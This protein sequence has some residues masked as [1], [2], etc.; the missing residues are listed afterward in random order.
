ME[1]E[2]EIGEV[3]E[4]G[5]GIFTM[6]DIQRLEKTIGDMGQ[7]LS[8]QIEAA[9]TRV[10]RRIDVVDKNVDDLGE[11]VRDL[12]TFKAVTESR[13]AS[14]QKEIEGNRADLGRLQSEI[15][16]SEGSCRERFIGVDLA[17]TKKADE[18]KVEEKLSA[19]EE[20]VVTKESVR[21][22]MLGAT[23]VG[24]IVGGGGVI[25]ALKLLGGL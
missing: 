22:A 18:S 17:L 11:D 7:A 14:G 12:L 23:I 4:F 25:G 1:V 2:L 6:S 20:K 8:K 21:M 15:A 24:A 13:L 5:E 3:G 10:I 9:E 16:R 19:L